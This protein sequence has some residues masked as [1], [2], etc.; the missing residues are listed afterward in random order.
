M[1]LTP[2]Q[3]FIL[4]RLHSLGFEI[5]AFHMYANYIGV[6]WGPQV[7]GKSSLGDKAVFAAL[8]A[9]AD[10]SDFTL[11]AEPTILINGNFS[12]RVTRSGR[13]LFVWKNQEV[14]ATHTLLSALA[15]FRSELVSA[16]DHKL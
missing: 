6:K 9:P 4:E 3:M 5:V 13:D 16:L 11:F 1:D 10:S 7:D 12:V 2:Q 15:N 14:E 8:L